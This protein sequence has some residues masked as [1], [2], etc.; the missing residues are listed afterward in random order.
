MK[1]IE[2]KIKGMHCVGCKNTVKE[3]ILSLKGVKDAKVDYARENAKVEFDA[4]KTDVKNVMKAIKNAGF[5][6]E[7]K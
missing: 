3:A 1:K 7:M 6:A 5:E 4:T 2:M